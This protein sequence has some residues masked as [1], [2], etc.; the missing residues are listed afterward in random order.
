MECHELLLLLLL[1]LVVV[2]KIKVEGRGGGKV[3]G[4]EE[5]GKTRPIESSKFVWKHN[6]HPINCVLNIFSIG[7]R[8]L[9][10]HLP[11]SIRF[12]RLSP[13]LTFSSLSKTCINI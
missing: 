2:I 4:E 1:L 9:L 12:L 13:S 11:A 10:C 6:S 5:A 8:Y 3:E 7:G